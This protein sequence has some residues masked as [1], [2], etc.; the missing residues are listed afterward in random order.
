MTSVVWLVKAV[1]VY[2]T[3]ELSSHCS[4]LDLPRT[5]LGPRH[6][7]PEARPNPVASV[8]LA[9]RSQRGRMRLIHSFCAGI[10]SGPC[11]HS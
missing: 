1:V 8:G 6:Q 5:A 2:S 10:A 3:G 11:S 9:K 4:H 7:T